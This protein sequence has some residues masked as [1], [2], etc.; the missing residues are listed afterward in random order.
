MRV[1]KRFWIK[2][3]ENWCKRC[4]QYSNRNE[5]SHKSYR[6]VHRPKIIH[7]SFSPADDDDYCVS[8][9]TL[10]RLSRD[11]AKLRESG[12]V[13]HFGSTKKTIFID[14]VMQSVDAAKRISLASVSLSNSIIPNPHANRSTLMF[15]KNCDDDDIHEVINDILVA[16]EASLLVCNLYASS[17]KS[18]PAPNDN[19][20]KIVKFVQLQMRETIFPAVDPFFSL[21]QSG[22][23]K[24]GIERIYRKLVQI[25]DVCM[26]LFAQFSFNDSI[27]FEMS[28][29]SVKSFF[30]DNI[31]DMQDACL[32]LVTTVSHQHEIDGN[33]V[34]S[35]SF[36]S[37]SDFSPKSEF[38]QPNFLQY[39]NDDRSHGAFD[40][41]SE[42]IQ[43]AVKRR[44]NPNGHGTRL[45]TVAVLN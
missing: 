35:S 4:A 45:T 41:E 19:M 25:I 21:E 6:I 36:I 28:A 10:T 15:T 18:K 22:S 9:K 29:V 27:V 5:Q 30:V 44:T 8:T 43:I 24:R 7:I 3:C 39:P 23:D 38:A 37:F 2:F 33:H 31:G 42:T 16:A 20:R 17:K 1:I 14:A 12:D 13:Y 34:Q 32:R 26:T 40:T 11:V